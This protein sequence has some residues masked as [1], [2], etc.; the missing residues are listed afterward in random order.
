MKIA[1]KG[2]PPDDK[3]IIYRGSTPTVILDFDDEDLDFA[4]IVKARVIMENSDKRNHKVFNDPIIDREHRQISVELS[5]QDT[6]HFDY[7]N[8]LLQAKIKL[9]NERVVISDIPVLL[10]EKTL[11]DEPI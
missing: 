5:Q 7:G 2:G 9:Q 11:D 1:C 6:F 4:D 10:V 3:L 8:L